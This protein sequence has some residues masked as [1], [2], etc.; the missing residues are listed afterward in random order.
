MIALIQPFGILAV[1]VIPLVGVI[2]F[3]WSVFEV[4]FLYWF[5]NV[6]IGITQTIKIWICTRTNKIDDR[7]GT[8]SF[9]AMHYGLFTFVHGVFVIVLF[10]VVAKGLATYN[11]GLFEPILAIVFWQFATLWIDHNGSEGFKGQ[12]PDTLM[13][14]PYPRLMALH[15]AIIA[16]GW[17][18]TE[19]GS[20]IWP[21]ALLVVLKT[22]VDLALAVF[23]LPSGSGN[24]IAALRNRRD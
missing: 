12:S 19:L 6:A 3:G 7:F 15:I 2:W 17:L 22:L 16:A 1:N 21:L 11:G 14:Q 4:V 23:N 18:I 20:P 13:F 10:G 24:V 5:E 8:A 9:F